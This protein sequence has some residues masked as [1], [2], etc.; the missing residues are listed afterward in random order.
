MSE[1]CCLEIQDF[2]YKGFQCTIVQFSRETL[3][4][5]HTLFMDMIDSSLT[6]NWWLG[7]VIIPKNH[8]YHGEQ[9]N[10]IPINCHGGLTYANTLHW[11]ESKN[12]G[13]FAIGFD[14]N[15]FD[16]GGGSKKQAELECKHIIEELRN[17]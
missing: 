8:K 13:K 3:K 14:F 15:H 1:Y 7:Y 17:E 11:E 12:K 4:P 6:Q 5:S 16:D 9:Y 10:D 2:E